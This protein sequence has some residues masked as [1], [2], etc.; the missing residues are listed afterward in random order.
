MEING[1]LGNLTHRCPT[2]PEPMVTKLG[3]GDDV[4]TSTPVQNF[5]TIR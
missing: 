1:K 4:G 5:I 2:K 3:V